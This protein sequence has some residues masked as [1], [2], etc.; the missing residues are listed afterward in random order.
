MLISPFYKKKNSNLYSDIVTL[1]KFFFL[2]E[3][4][5]TKSNQFLVDFCDV[6]TP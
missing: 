4:G 6:I 1:I 2:S 3:Y 5:T